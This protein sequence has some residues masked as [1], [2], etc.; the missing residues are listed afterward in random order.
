[1]SSDEWLGTDGI[2]T[3]DSGACT[4]KLTVQITS[5]IIGTGRFSRH[6]LPRIPQHLLDLRKAA[7]VSGTLCRHDQSFPP[8]IES[9]DWPACRPM[10]SRLDQENTKMSRS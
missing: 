1:M 6:L 10:E 8:S 2:K 4:L 9:H 5:R 7:A 3:L